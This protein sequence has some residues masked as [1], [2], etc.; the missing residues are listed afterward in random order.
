MVGTAPVQNLI[1]QD[2]L[3][4]ADWGMYLSKQIKLDLNCHHIGTIQSFNSID[5]TAYV[6][7]NYK[8]T[9]LSIDDFGNT[10]YVNAD[11]PM[12]INAPVVVLGGGGGLLTFPIASGDEC[13]IMCNDRDID[14]WFQGSSSSANA[15][16]RLHAFTDAIILVGLRST[17]N[18][19]LDYNGSGTELR[20]KDGLTKITVDG[21]SITTTIDGGTTEITA[22][23]SKVTIDVGDIMTVEID[24]TG[25][26]K[27]TNST[28]GGELFQTIAN[29]FNDVQTGLVT[30]MLGPEP[31]I[32]PAFATHY[33]TL[34]NYL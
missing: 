29:L 16:G 32:M 10:S 5:Q 2:N 18:I 13:L 14:N 19:I 23:T 11:Y 12:I 33:T 24:A 22:T 21:E 3:Q 26:I 28:A 34:G 30:T 17:P 20:T 9:S 15:T 31:L 8:K 25:K 27:I 6:T 4:L 1:P 7:V